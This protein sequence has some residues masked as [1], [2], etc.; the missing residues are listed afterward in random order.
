MS[1]YKAKKTYRGRIA[2]T[3]SGYLHEGHAQTFQVAWKRCRDRAGVL[4]FRNDDL[5]SFRCKNEFTTAAMEDLRNL[6]IDWDEGPDYG[7]FFG[8]YDQSKRGEYYKKVIFTLAQKGLIY[9]CI[10]S[11]KEIQSYRIK[12]RLGEEYLFP[13]ELRPDVKNFEREEV[14]L[15]KNWRFR[16]NW[17]TQ[18]NFKDERKGEQIFEIGKEFSD[19]LVWRKDG[20]AAYELATVVDDHFM[21]ITEIVRGEDLQV[22]SARQSLLFDVLKWPRPDFYHCELLLDENGRKLSKSKRNLPRLFF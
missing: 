9:P 18:I 20:F 12:A 19:F 3:P 1:E 2:P 14:F 6:K 8:P 22:S 21:Q 17:G 16:T 7:G 13:Q 10:K 5:D 11:R 15:N 4:T